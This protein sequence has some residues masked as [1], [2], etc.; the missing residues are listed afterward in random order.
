M[1]DEIMLKIE[2]LK[3]LKCEVHNTN[4]IIKE[5]DETY[6]T[7]DD[8]IFIDYIEKIIFESNVNL[9]MDFGESS[10]MFRIPFRVG[11]L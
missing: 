9:A 3:R 8:L 4:A 5:S 2:Y 1:L 6:T 10:T 11:K 7:H